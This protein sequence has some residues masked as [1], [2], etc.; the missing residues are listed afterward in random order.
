MSYHKQTRQVTLTEISKKSNKKPHTPY[1][2]YKQYNQTQQPNISTKN[3]LTSKT[4][5]FPDSHTLS[6]NPTKILAT[7]A[8]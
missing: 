3:V 8:T 5:A 4:I 7:K 1:L 6:L 2:R